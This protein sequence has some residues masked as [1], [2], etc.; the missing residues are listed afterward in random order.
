MN[1][2][3]EKLNCLLIPNYDNSI[4]KSIS[5]LKE[6]KLGGLKLFQVVQE[7]LN[8]QGKYH[9]RKEVKKNFLIFNVSV[10]NMDNI[11]SGYL[12]SKGDIIYINNVEYKI[13]DD[14]KEEDKEES[15]TEHLNND[16]LSSG[17]S[18]SIILK[19]YLNKNNDSNKIIDI[20]KS[21]LE[22]DDICLLISI[23]VKYVDYILDNLVK[24]KIYKFLDD[25]LSH[26]YKN[27]SI[28]LNDQS[29]IK[30][31]KLQLKQKEIETVIK[32]EINNLTSL[33][34]ID[35]FQKEFFKNIN[36]I[37]SNFLVKPF[38]NKS[39][40]SNSVVSNLFY[41]LREVLEVKRHEDK[42]I[43]YN[44]CH[45]TYESFIHNCIIAGGFN[46]LYL[47]DL[48]EKL[49]SFLR[50]EVFGEL[51]G[52][53]DLF[54]ENV[55]KKYPF[56]SEVGFN[57]YL[58]LTNI[59][60]GFANNVVLKIKSRDF[61]LEE[62]I[63]EINSFSGSMNI[64]VPIKKVINNK[65]PSLL[66]KIEWQN[67]NLQKESRNFL[68][69]IEN[70]KENIPWSDLKNKQPYMLVAITEQ[71]KLLGRDDIVNE[72]KNNIESNNLN[73]FIIYGQKRVGKTSVVRTVEKYF[74]ELV[75]D[76]IIISYVD[77]TSQR[78]ENVDDTINR[79]VTSLCKDIK[80][81]LLKNNSGNDSL[82]EKF[83][84]IEI[85]KLNNSFSPVEDFIDDIDLIKEHKIILIIDEFDELGYELFIP[86]NKSETFFSNLRGLNNKSLNIGIILVGSENM[87]KIYNWH[88]QKL[89]NW[90]NRKIDTF[91]IKYEYEPYEQLILKPVSPYL[92]YDKDS[93]YYIYEL[94]GGNPYF[95]NMI[96]GWVFSICYEK[97]DI[98]IT[99][100]EIT[101]AIDR[102]L[103]KEA[104]TSFQHFWMDG[105]LETSIKK[106]F[107]SDKRRR[108][109]LA[110]SNAMNKKYEESNKY[111]V[112]LNEIKR[113]YVSPPD[114]GLGSNECDN[115]I[116]DF[117]DRRIL[118]EKDLFFRIR[119]LL[120]EKWLLTVGS[121]EIIE[122]I[123]DLEKIK[124]EN[125]IDKK[126][127]LSEEEI[128]ELSNKFRYLGEKISIENIQNWLNQFD[129]N[130]LKRYFF[131]LLNEMNYISNDDL[132]KIFKNNSEHIFK[133]EPAISNKFF[134]KKK[135]KRENAMIAYSEIG[136]N[137]N[138]IFAKKFSEVA[139]IYQDNVKSI[140]I[141]IRN[142]SKDIKYLIILEPILDNM[143]EILEKLDKI[144]IFL[145]ER[146]F[147]D[148]TNVYIISIFVM[149]HTL[150]KFELILKNEFTNFSFIY[151]KVLDEKLTKPFEEI[152]NEKILDVLKEKIGRLHEMN[153]DF[154]YSK[155][156]TFECICPQNSIPFYWFHCSENIPLFPN[157]FE[158]YN[159]EIIDNNERYRDL[160]YNL[161]KKLEQT[162]SKVVQEILTKKYLDSWWIEGI[163]KAIRTKCVERREDENQKH[164]EYEYLDLIDFIEILKKNFTEMEKIFS[165]DF[166]KK[167]WVS[168]I[169]KEKAFSWLNRLN[170]I[171]RKYAHFVKSPPSEKDYL[172]L[173][174]ISESFYDNLKTKGI[175][176]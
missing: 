95:T 42:L 4:S 136:K 13:V 117:L 16:Y 155:N 67:I 114:L 124:E 160:C 37:E 116:K 147:L 50:E 68:L 38:F 106:D 39:L 36:S 22:S 118:K 141:C 98:E 85:P 71:D 171:R 76:N 41:P 126:Y 100:Q 125:E 97:K 29:F 137:E 47:K 91:D 84:S 149:E 32:N 131:N 35:N 27:L 135:Y 105:I 55:D 129:S 70:Q 62:Y 2:L 166:D 88:G 168:S 152:R 102:K 65:N 8:S 20:F 94:S 134:G 40:I 128:S 78:Q 148:N 33:Y 165:F 28:Q 150:H 115:Q 14:Y 154:N 25:N 123:V 112:S 86:N 92:K 151:F 5:L 61:R 138:I 130:Y 122:G 132:H 99:K 10:Y 59:G 159:F 96:C 69:H 80:K 12:V 90:I 169:G 83:Q 44:K 3:I 176:T 63:F 19:E 30:I 127:K 53:A 144:K 120:F 82:Y 17:E 113:E 24:I 11:N 145:N 103:K 72:L 66:I 49:F 121:S 104:K 156:I 158:L 58:K 161:G 101:E 6:Y 60:S 93:I 139:N 48:A 172:F 173:K 163:P 174:L 45:E 164:T 111:E 7:I 1:D 23:H 108:V 119:P 74:N 54:I 133:N 57:I 46:F 52:K 109:L 89:N 75:V 21:E 167:Q 146:E 140:D 9:S 162:I 157:T 26:V 153:Y 64:S 107:L 81:K 15:T 143:E 170:E 110:I 51:S 56:H 18:Y 87:Q 43:I 175:S 73:S 142:F 34:Q 77:G 31:Q 79:L